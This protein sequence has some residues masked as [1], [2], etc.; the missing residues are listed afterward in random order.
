MDV[1][2]GECMLCHSR[3]EGG[4]DNAMTTVQHGLD[5]ISAQ[6]MTESDAHFALERVVGGSGFTLDELRAQ[7]RS[8]EFSTLRARLAWIAVQAIEGT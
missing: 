7:A 5:M 3:T 2:V 8:G 4:G 1:S 6:R